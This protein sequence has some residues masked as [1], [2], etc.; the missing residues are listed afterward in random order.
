VE[1][2][3]PLGEE[4]L[5][6]V[7]L[8]PGLR[9][10]RTLISWLLA[11]ALLAWLAFQVEPSAVKAGLRV[12][13]PGWLGVAL[14]S[15]AATLVLRVARWR[16]LLMDALGAYPAWAT[17]WHVTLWGQGLNLLLPFRA[18]DLARAFG[19]RHQEKGDPAYALGT[20]GA[21]K[22]LDLICLG[23]ALSSIF[24]LPFPTSSSGTFRWRDHASG[25]FG[26]LST[27]RIGIP[28]LLLGGVVVLAWL[29]NWTP[30]PASRGRPAWRRIGVNGLRR[31]AAGLTVLKRPAVLG[32]AVVWSIPLWLCHAFNNYAAARA[33]GI[34]MDWRGALVVLVVLQAGLAPPSTPAKIGTFQALCVAGLSLLGHSPA[35]GLAYGLVLQLVVLLPL[36]LLLLLD[37]SIGRR[38]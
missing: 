36:C 9:R 38:P 7:P 35:V 13:H 29:L 8:R 32:P 28:F 18:G 24:L 25:L 23:G 2:A 30:S 19:V 31:L 22:L 12:I 11:A 21:E 10:W 4:R 3:R 33:L 6:V 1:K 20:I 16:V 27:A 34:G 5:S 37:I 17:V 15:V 26:L 14:L